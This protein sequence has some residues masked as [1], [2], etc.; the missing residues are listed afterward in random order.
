M[1]ASKSFSRGVWEMAC[2]RRIAF[3]FRKCSER[4]GG[5]EDGKQREYNTSPTYLFIDECLDNITCMHIND[6]QSSKRHSRKFAQGGT[7][8]VSQPF[9]LLHLKP[10]PQ[11]WDVWD[12]CNRC[13]P[14][15]REY[16]LRTCT[17]RSPKSALYMMK[18]TSKSCLTWSYLQH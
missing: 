5:S 8:E 7:H 14:M 9:E 17:R 2:I 4:C 3:F 6:N 13:A 10:T 18:E 15:E 11:Q 12:R 16:T 1:V